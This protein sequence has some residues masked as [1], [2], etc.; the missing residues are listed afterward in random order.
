MRQLRDLLIALIILAAGFSAGYK[1]GRR[2]N[3]T[4]D[5]M[6]AEYGCLMGAQYGCYKFD[7]EL[8]IDNCLSDAPSF[9]EKTAKNFETFLKNGK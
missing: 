3:L 7:E 1:W 6:S 9:C 5:K 2:K 8:D 4:A